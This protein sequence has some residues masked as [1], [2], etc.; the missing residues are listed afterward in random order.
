MRCPLCQSRPARRQ[1]PALDRTIC[2]VCCGTKRR[3]EI[4]CPDTCGYLANS[5]AHPPVIVQRQ[6]ERDVAALL[7]ALSG[8]PEA[9][10]QLFF[11]T[12]SLIDRHRGDDLGLDAATDADVADALASL[13]G[14]FETAARGLIYE[15]RAGSLPA[16]RLAADIKH[17]YDELG[18]DRPSGF[19]EEASRVLRRLEACVAEAHRAGLDTRRGFLDLAGR[20]AARLGAPDPDAGRTPAP[21]PSII[22][23]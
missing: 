22:I 5:Q 12:L 3:A 17:V 18:H 7:P 20:M 1:C 13:A 11:L 9:H 21:Q 4:R 16:Q 2:P 15:Q 10:Q 23:P 19:A 8:L 14:T 6:H